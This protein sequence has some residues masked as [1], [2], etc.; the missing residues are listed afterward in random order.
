M[1][2]SPEWWQRAVEAGAVFLAG[3]FGVRHGRKTSPSL[4]T[5]VHLERRMTDLE[6]KV[7]R[8]EVTLAVMASE[9][10]HVHE[11]LE[12][13]ENKLDGRVVERRARPREDQ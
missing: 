13:I 6:T 2:D 1:A 12:R 9:Y 5:C 8:H 11:A 10:K 7:D 4:G 3:L